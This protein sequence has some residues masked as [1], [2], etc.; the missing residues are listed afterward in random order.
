MKGYYSLSVVMVLFLLFLSYSMNTVEARPL[1]KDH[2]SSSASSFITSIINR[3]YS[4]PSHRVVRKLR[5]EN[6]IQHRIS[7]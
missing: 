7:N 5:N 1:L 2:Q 3:A 6:H 4:G